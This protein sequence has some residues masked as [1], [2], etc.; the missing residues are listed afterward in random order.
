MAASGLDIVLSPM[1]NINVVV[2]HEKLFILENFINYCHGENYN[3]EVIKMIVFKEKS[4]LINHLY[5]LSKSE[6][7]KLRSYVNELKSS[8]LER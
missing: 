7:A 6:N 1:R 3:E 8:K 2:D 4:E 5:S